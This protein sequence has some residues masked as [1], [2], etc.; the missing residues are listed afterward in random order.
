MR[1][2]YARAETSVLINGV[3]SEP[4]RI[5]RGVRQGDPL[6]CLLFDLAI[7]PLSAMIR[8]A[9]IAGIHIPRCC[10]SLKATLF[11]D[12]TTVYLSAEDDFEA[13][14]QVLS[15][16]C[17]AAKARFN[18]KKTEIIPIGTPMYRAEVVNTYRDTGKWKNYPENVHVAADGEPVR[19][20]GA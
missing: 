11:A 12:N 3:L 9:D 20:L 2:L 16:W 15:V 10:E 6:S 8:K 1:A 13:L 18:L 7:E 14:Q 19:I 5:T 17:G 4:F